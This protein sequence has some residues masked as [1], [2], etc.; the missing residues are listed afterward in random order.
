MKKI[1]TLIVLAVIAVAGCF[2]QVVPSGYYRVKNYGLENYG[3]SKGEKVQAYI[4]IDDDYYQIV[5]GSGTAQT[6]E[7]VH[8]WANN[9]ATAAANRDQISS[10]AS[11]IYVNNV[12]GNNYDLEG[13]GTGVHKLIGYYL[14]PT[15]ESIAD[16]CYS[17]KGTA[18]GATVYLWTTYTKAANCYRCTT[19]ATKANS[20]VAYRD[21]ILEPISAESETSYFGVQPKFSYNNKYYAP[22]YAS[23]PFRTASSNMHVLYAKSASSTGTITF[24]EVESDVIP[25]NTPCLIECTSMNTKDNKIDIL[26]GDYPAIEGNLLSGKLFCNT[27]ISLSKSEN[28]RTAFDASTMRTWNISSN[29][30]VLSKATNNLTIYNSEYFLNANE[31][32]LDV[33]KLPSELQSR[34]SWSLSIPTFVGI[35][36]IEANEEAVAKTYYTLDGKQL[37]APQPGMNIVKMSNG[38]VKKVMVR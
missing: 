21:W 27:C 1:T 18:Y 6:F 36:G 19:D 17:V 35:D 15:K 24:A 28:C 12:S 32:Y 14:T 31:S 38:K 3:N 20:I 13:Q 33:S 10:P 22:F 9:D 7:Q 34:T 26:R 2:A 4:F 8:V 29:K 37:S 11:V 25:A 5:T 30:L 16:D 23:F